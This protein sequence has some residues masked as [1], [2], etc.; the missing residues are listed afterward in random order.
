MSD[1][2]SRLYYQNQKRIPTPFAIIFLFLIMIGLSSTLNQQKKVAIKAAKNQLVRL[3]IINV[4]NNSATI[5]WRTPE[6]LISWLVY[7]EEK[8]QLNNQVFD[9]RDV[10]GKREARFNH[11]AILKNLKPNKKYFFE[12][13]TSK[14]VIKQK[15]NKPFSF[16][17]K[18]QLPQPVNLPPARGRIQNRNG[19]PLV[20]AIVILKIEGADPLGDRTKDK[21]EWLIPF[22]YLTKANSNDFFQLEK[23]NLVTI[24][25]ISEEGEKSIVKA[26]VK[27]ITP[28]KT[29]IIGKDY[30]FLT[31]EEKVLSEITQNR[32]SFQ[33]IDII[34]PKEGSAIHG[35][36]PLFRGLALPRKK[37]KI[38]IE[39]KLRQAVEVYSDEDGVWKLIPFYDLEPGNNKI[40]LIT[41][42]EKGKEITLTRNFIISKSGEGVLGEATP[43]AELTPSPVKE[44]PTPT[45]LIETPTSLPPTPTKSFFLTPTPSPIISGIDF[46]PLTVLATALIFLG[47][48]LVIIF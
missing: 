19:T 34:F 8:N 24:E 43:S 37:V 15:D 18:V 4:T 42:D 9:E 12:I 29:I 33:K 5:F 32:S 16:S 13:V 44:T 2:Y 14:E 40:I 21:G 6:K 1:I 46:F 25:I 23:N 36:K 11:Y 3:E 39:S 10:E 22:F 7:G 35:K 45:P 28:L 48:G 27:K 47:G 38:I 31:E 17:T 26:L 20:D 30:E 41:E